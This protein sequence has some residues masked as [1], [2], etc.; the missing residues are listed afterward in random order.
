[1]VSHIENEISTQIN[2]DDPKIHLEEVEIEASNQIKLRGDVVTTGFYDLTFYVG[3]HDV[4]MIEKCLEYEPPQ[5]IPCDYE[6]IHCT[7]NREDKEQC[8]DQTIKVIEADP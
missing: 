8:G 2:T 6:E 5:V 3:Y 7:L 1:M 4:E